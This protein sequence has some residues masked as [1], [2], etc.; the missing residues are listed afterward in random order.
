MRPKRRICC[1][2]TFFHEDCGE[3]ITLDSD[4]LEEVRTLIKLF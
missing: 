4:I 1:K 3:Q 2:H